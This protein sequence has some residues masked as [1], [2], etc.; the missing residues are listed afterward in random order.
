MNLS[1]SVRTLG[2]LLLVVGCSGFACA[3]RRTSVGM[4]ARIDDLVLPEVLLAAP[5]EDKKTP[6]ILRILERVPQGTQQRYSIEYYGFEPGTFDLLDF[7]V[8]ADGQELDGA[9]EVLVTIEPILPVEDM[10]PRDLAVQEFDSV[11]GYRFWMIFLGIAWGVGLLVILL[12]GRR[13]G[14]RK[15]RAVPRG[16]LTLADRL[17]P[18][19]ES[20]RAGTLDRSRKAELERL[21]LTYWRRRLNLLDVRPERAFAALRSHAE[22][23]PLVRSLEEWLHRPGGAEDV[24]VEVLLRPYANVSADTR[25]IHTSSQEPR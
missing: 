19:V 24:E 10:E 4:P 14:W 21:L 6:V 2:L 5:I 25:S 13:F 16:P 11:G 23:G 22:A 17:R 1:R 12:A 15:E 8:R 3:Q 18:L 9:P 20:A 7:L